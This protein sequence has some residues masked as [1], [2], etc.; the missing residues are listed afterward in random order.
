MAA[1]PNNVDKSISEAIKSLEKLRGD[2]QSYAE[3]W[4]D[5]GKKIKNALNPINSFNKSI[6]ESQKKQIA[7]Q[8]EI[9]KLEKKVRPGVLDSN[10][11]KLKGAKD[12]LEVEKAIEKKKQIQVQMIK[13]AI[14]GVKKLLQYYNEYDKLLS[15]NAKLQSTSKDEIDSQYESIQVLNST[16]SKYR[17]SN[18]EVLASVSAL[19]KNYDAISGKALVKIA[20]G[21]AAI[22]R[23]TGLSVE[24]SSKFF[25]TMSEIGNTSLQSQKNME[26]I[27]NLAAKA[28][29]V[30]LGRVIKDVANASNNVRLI[31]K[32]NTTELIKQAAELR[33]IGTN[34]D[35]AAKSAESLLNFE[36][37]IGAELKLSALLGK[38]INFN[39]S[40]RLFFAGKTLEAEKALQKEI[41]TVG[42]LDNLNY[43]QRK[44]L[45]EATG[46]E[47]AELQKIQT[48]K[49]SLL[50]AEREYPEL[51]K[52]RLD[53]E[54]DLASIQKSSS[55]QRKEELALM[56][57]QQIA[58]T[59]LKQLEQARA[60]I[61]NNIGRIIKPIT[62][63]IMELQLGILRVVG[64]LTNVGDDSTK[65]SLIIMGGVTAI[66]GSFL[67]LQKG[68]SAAASALSKGIGKTASSVGTGVGNG[69]SNAAQG[70]GRFGKVLAGFP[71]AAIGKLAL[72]M[73]ILTVSVIGL[74]YAFSLLG[75]TSAGQI[76]AF[77]AA[78]VILGTS[79]ALAGALM[80]G[81]QIVG[82]YLFAG[83]LVVLGIAA[84]ELGFAMKLAAPAIESIGKTLTILASIAGGV[85]VKAFDTMLSVFQ[86]L[87]GVI[88]SIASSLVTITNIGFT[89]L[90]TSAAG[91]TALSSSIKSLGENL[92][93]FPISQLTNIV[94]ELSIL[95][96]SAEG[97]SLAIRSLKDLS[98]IDLPSLDMDVKGTENLLKSTEAK[99]KQTTELKEGLAIVA[100]KIEVLTSLMANGGI[101][102]NLDGQRL[103]AALSKTNYRSGG[104]GQSTTLA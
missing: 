19:R 24:E 2:T 72:I 27:A 38:N 66:I 55:E 74:A 71:M 21:S 50:E 73:G 83:A 69:L 68:A 45:A 98:G 94:S 30:P 34:L 104:F 8:V 80:T 59:Q 12:Q 41:E 89:K 23:A 101:G 64:S 63:K 54:R 103:N 82:I 87:P 100:Q 91:V 31:F 76:L 51:A 96:Q 86:S 44:A 81:P 11:L 102:I 92:I 57:K 33:K 14:D 42:D 60:E 5:V 28:A 32:G 49:K 88:T 95:S 29:G 26:G 6:E 36:S 70:I 85:I 4:N 61:F 1:N 58:E 35:A 56:L 40:R 9:N 62:D 93:N 47:F 46:K 67:L 39:E 79:L 48:Q 65:L 7:L 77:S 20:E 15:E 18:Q 99:E 53:A 16:Y 25:E 37:S 3:T 84:M 10:S 90:T 17:I 52:Q 97:L 22:S 75:N 78:L 43:L 13:L